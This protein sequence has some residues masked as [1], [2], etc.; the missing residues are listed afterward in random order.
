[1]IFINCNQENFEFKPLVDFVRDNRLPFLDALIVTD[2]PPGAMCIINGNG[3]KEF[4]A[5]ND[6]ELNLTFEYAGSYT[7]KIIAE[8]YKEV[9][10]CE[11]A[12]F[13][14]V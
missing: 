1:M 5:I 14:A 2:I 7:V 3:Y 8:N 12:S 4:V 9:F 6:G 11:S 10:T 13:N